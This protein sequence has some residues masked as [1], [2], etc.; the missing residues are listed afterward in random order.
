[1]TR[2]PITMLTLLGDLRALFTREIALI[3]AA[4]APFL[5]LPAYAVQLLT[6]ALPKF[7]AER[8]QV[9]IARW[10]DAVAIWG[11]ANVGWYLLAD[12]LAVFGAGALTVLLIDPRR[13]TVG[14]A[15]ARATQL[16][17]R[18]ILAS[19]LMAIPVNL[20]MWLIL[21]GLYFQARFILAAP[22]LAL[23]PRSAIGALGRSWRLT[24]QASWAVF[25][26]LVAVF[27]LWWMV[28]IPLAPLDGWLRSP[29][30]LNPFLLAL[31]DGALAAVAALYQAAALVLG[32]V[33][34]RRLAS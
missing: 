11:Q 16:W 10:L 34:Y 6:P 12:A 25:A 5:F 1:M 2:P 24:G 14:Q 4:G 29:G 19:V 3:V 30:H 23:E 32:V 15:L 17:P 13:P 33:A 7:P 18:F 31:V 27:A 8:T 9:A 28:L 21:P 20:G 22:V 26:S